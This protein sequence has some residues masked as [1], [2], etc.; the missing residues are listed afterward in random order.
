LSIGDN[1]E[2]MQRTQ[3]RAVSKVKRALME[4]QADRTDIIVDKRSGEVFAGIELRSGSETI[5]V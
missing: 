5:S 2:K 4:A 3:G 1:E